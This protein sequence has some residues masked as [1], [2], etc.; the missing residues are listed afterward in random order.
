MNKLKNRAW[1]AALCCVLATLPAVAAGPAQA[2]GNT[3]YTVAEGNKVDAQTLSGW[4]TWR[5]MACERCHGAAQ[6]GMVGPSLV[7]SLKVLNKDQFKAV[8]LKGR[9]EKGMPNF[10][11]SKMV[12]ENIDNLY[13]YLKGRSDGAI[14]PGRL[15]EIGK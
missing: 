12:T 11:G 5:A 8:V 4:K 7:D 2:G 15:Q 1:T 9:I 3:P 13:G 6:E 14:E 10:D